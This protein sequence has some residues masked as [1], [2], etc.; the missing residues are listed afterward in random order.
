[1]NRAKAIVQAAIAAA[2]LY[3]AALA[4]GGALRVF[5]WAAGIGG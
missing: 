1:M 2:V 5:M 4:L 3:G